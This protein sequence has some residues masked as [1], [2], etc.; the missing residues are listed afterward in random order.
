M[1]SAVADHSSKR[2]KYTLRTRRSA[3][4]STELHHTKGVLQALLL[5]SGARRFPPPPSSGRWR[6]TQHTLTCCG[7]VVTFCE[8]RAPARRPPP[9]SVAVFG[10]VRKGK[11]EISSSTNNKS[12]HSSAASSWRDGVGLP[13]RRAPLGASVCPLASG[14]SFFVFGGGRRHK[15]GA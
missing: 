12:A 13:V 4:V 8:S 10:K 5:L 11:S 3:E 7:V 2:T 9:P 6:Q 1:K 15:V 14:V